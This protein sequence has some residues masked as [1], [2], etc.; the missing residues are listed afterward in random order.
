MISL[1]DMYWGMLLRTVSLCIGDNSNCLNCSLH[2]FLMNAHRR[3]QRFFNRTLYIIIYF[4]VF[5]RKKSYI[6]K[7]RVTPFKLDKIIEGYS[8]YPFCIYLDLML[9]SKS[10]SLYLTL[11]LNCCHLDGIWQISWR[12]IP[13]DNCY[14]LE[15]FSIIYLFMLNRMLLIL[16][17]L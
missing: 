17:L 1:A 6:F 10:I 8:R 3:Q 16:I 5:T 4:L 2:G 13:I 14:Y 7:E 12:E 11:Q 15:T 9:P